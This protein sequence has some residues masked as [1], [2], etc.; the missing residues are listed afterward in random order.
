[1]QLSLVGISHTTAPVAV[2]E[3]FAFSAE[4]LPDLLG[5]LG[6]RYGGATVLSTCNRTE[7]Y[8]ASARGIGDPRP[9][10]ALLSETKGDVAMEGA[11]FFAATGTDAVR[12]LFLV[13]AG[14]E[15]MVIGEAEV[16]GQVRAAFAAATAAGTHTPILSRAFH[17][18]VRV[19]RKVRAQTNISRGTTSIS[20]AAAAL[21]RTTLGDLAGK[22]ALV[23]GAGDAGM[24][25]ARAL[26]SNGVSSIVVTSRSAERSAAVAADLGGT[27]AP[28]EELGASLAAADVVITSTAAPHFLIAPPMIAS[29]MLGRRARPLLL[30]DIA[31]P[32]DVDP[33]VRSVPGVHLHDIDDLQAMAGESMR[34]RRKELAPAQAIVN[35]A[36]EKYGAWL[37][38]LEVVPTV[39]ALRSRAESLRVAELE[40]TLARTSMNSADRARVEAM[41]SALVKKLL[42][43]PVRRLKQPGEGA[44]YV[45]A[46]RAL[47]GL[48]APEGE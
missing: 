28:F 44:R 35:E 12:H 14:I 25:A 16:L 5:R 2:R 7:V 30:I 26:V 6:E 37:R 27:A 41:T 10:V 36:V 4:E 21:A 33:D 42:H 47:F 40:R 8:V 39:A 45:E 48:D 3:H 1:V 22:T 20:A 29:A 46:T 32:R 34:R 17:E 11:P 9:I 19:G 18:A 15:S 24:L 38:S 13:A 23:I 43:E 31:V